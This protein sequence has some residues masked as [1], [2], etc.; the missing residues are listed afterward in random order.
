MSK[1][2]ALMPKSMLKDRYR[3]KEVLGSNGFSITYMVYDTFREMNC[4]VRELFPETIVARSFADKVQVEVLHMSNEALFAEMIEHVIRQ[5]KVMI[6]HFPLEGIANIITYFEEN[7]TVYVVSEYIAGTPLSEFL[8]HRQTEKFELASILNFFSPMIESLKKLHKEQIYHGKIRPDEI[9]ITKKNGVKLVGFAEPMQDIVKPAFLEATL[10]ARNSMYAAVEQF[11]EGGVLG[12]YTDVYGLTATIYHCITRHVPMDFYDR[13]GQKDKMRSPLDLGAKISEAQDAAI[14]KGLS[15][16]AFERYQT[17]EDLLEAIYKG[18]ESDEFAQPK[19]IILY[20][21]PFAFLQKQKN[22]RRLA[23]AAG[24]AAV[25]LLCILVPKF[26]GFT[27]NVRANSFYKK[28][29]KSSMYEQCESLKWLSDAD[30]KNFTNDY[31][32]LDEEGK[33]ESVYYDIRNKKLV[34]RKGFN[35]KGSLYNFVEID[36]RVNNVAVVV[37]YDR[38]TMRTLMVDLNNL[39]EAYQVTEMIETKGK[40][41]Q[42]RHLEVDEAT[43]E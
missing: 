1:T 43:K 41:T 29:V 6:K 3:I 4:V 30:R 35:D 27:G 22:K 40:E 8:K 9:I 18:A 7:N 38:E 23:M 11:M 39:G 17:I 20:Q 37:F 33:I 25:I 21:P 10:P 5:A 16:Y 15:S 32:Q 36:Y 13:I 19:P 14:M 24:T 28:F 31:S 12:T 34:D 26:L 42:T 2:N